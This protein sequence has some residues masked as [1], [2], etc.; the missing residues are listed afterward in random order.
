MT[1]AAFDPL[2]ILRALVEHDVR[3]VVVG[4]IAGRL[5]GSTTVTNDLHICY[6]RDAANLGAL[7]AAL[8]ALKAKLRGADRDVPFHADAKTL[9]MG[10][11][12]TFVT[13]AGNLDCLGTPAGTAGY[14]QLMRTATTMDA[15]VTIAVA[16]IDDLIL[17]KRAAG[18]L[19]D[20][21]ELAILT[22]VRDEMRR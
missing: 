8:R 4:G 17:M 21:V 22:A 11:P 3:F 15:G 2:R 13:V 9:Q 5:C 7:A 1:V 10:D 6:A 19:K 12:F 18:R 14:D 16:S 20:L